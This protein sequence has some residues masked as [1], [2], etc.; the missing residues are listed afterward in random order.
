MTEAAAVES[1]TPICILNSDLS[2]DAKRLWCPCARW[3]SANGKLS[4]KNLDEFVWA[5][6]NELGLEPA[7]VLWLTEEL[8]RSGLHPEIFARETTFNELADSINART[9]RLLKAIGRLNEELLQE[10][11]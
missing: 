7:R 11:H 4:A 2:D 3:G 10:A 8:I 9:V 1:M 6:S 5:M